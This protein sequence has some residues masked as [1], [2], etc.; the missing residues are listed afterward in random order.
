MLMGPKRAYSADGLGLNKIEDAKQFC[1]NDDGASATRQHA[2]LPMCMAGQGC[3]TTAWHPAPVNRR[4]AA[5][6]PALHAGATAPDKL[7]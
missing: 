2:A 1:R 4:Y 3:R 5:R 7:Q 6:R